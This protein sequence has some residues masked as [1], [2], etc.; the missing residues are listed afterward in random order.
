MYKLCLSV[1][2]P[3]KYILAETIIWW[4]MMACIASVEY[5]FYGLLL[6]VNHIFYLG[7]I[8]PILELYHPL[9]NTV[10]IN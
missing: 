10:L 2:Q 3:H 5:D 4:Y 9:L 1:L 8:M 7:N 6:P